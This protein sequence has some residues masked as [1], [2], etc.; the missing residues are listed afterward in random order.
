MSRNKFLSLDGVIL[1]FYK[2]FWN[3]LEVEF[4]FMLQESIHKRNLLPSMT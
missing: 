3:S 4:L 2:V 1:E